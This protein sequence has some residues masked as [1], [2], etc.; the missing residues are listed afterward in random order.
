MNMKRFFANMSLMIALA[1]ASVSCERAEGLQSRP[2][3]WTVPSNL[4][5]SDMTVTIDRRT[6]PPAV[7]VSQYDLLGAF[8][9]GQCRGVAE[10]VADIDGQV[11]FYLVIHSL[12]T[13]SGRDNM[14]VELRYYS[15]VRRDIYYARPFGFVYESSLGTMD[16]PYAPQW[17]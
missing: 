10:P 13:D 15:D 1:V 6:L 11:R 8:I 12:T 3:D 5:Y 2:S 14:Q 4:H 17:K 7:T 16:E 9:D